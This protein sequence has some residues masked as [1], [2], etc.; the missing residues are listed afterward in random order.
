V[1]YEIRYDPERLEKNS[2]T[3]KVL[4]EKIVSVTPLSI[5]MTSRSD[6]GLLRSL[7]EENGFS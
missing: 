7:I 5:D 4:I 2:D 3:Y 1:A 6:F